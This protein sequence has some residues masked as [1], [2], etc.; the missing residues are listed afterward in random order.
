MQAGFTSIET[1]NSRTKTTKMTLYK[2]LVDHS[3]GAVVWVLFGWGLYTGRNP[4][5]AGD[6]SH[7]FTE[8]PVSEYPVVFQ[9]FGFAATAA[10]I[11]S[12]GVLGRIRLAPYFF[13]SAFSTGIIY[14]IVAHS[15]WNSNGFLAQLGYLDFAGS[16]IVHL[17][18][19]CFGFVGAWA[20]GPRVHRFKL[21]PEFYQQEDSDDE[22]EDGDD[23]SE[24][25]ED[26]QPPSRA[27][28]TNNNTDNGRI[29]PIKPINPNKKKKKPGLT[30]KE[31]FLAALCPSRKY[32]YVREPPGSSA[33]LSALGSLLLFVA[34]FC[35][36]AGS[37]L[38]IDTP[39]KYNTAARAALN[40]LLSYGAASSTAFFYSLGTSV[41]R[42]EYHIKYDLNLLINGG[43]AGLVVVT[44][45]C[46]YI[47]PWAA[48]LIGIIS[49]FAYVAGDRLI[50]RVLMID[51]PL[52][53]TAVHGVNGFL[54]VVWIGFAHRE[55]GIFYGGDGSMLGIQILGAIYITIFS[56][57]LAALFF[58]P[59]KL[60]KRGIYLFHD[61]NEQLVGLD[62][63]HFDHEGSLFVQMEADDLDSD[64]RSGHNSNTVR[65]ASPSFSGGYNN[66]IT[67][68]RTPQSSSLSI[69]VNNTNNNEP[70][71]SYAYGNKISG[72][73]K[74]TD[75][76]EVRKPGGGGGG[77]DGDKDSQGDSSDY[78]KNTA[79]DLRAVM[80]DRRLRKRFRHYLALTR[81]DENIRFY[82]HVEKFQAEKNK[83]KRR[84]RAKVIFQ[85]FILDSAPT[86]INL[87]SKLKKKLEEYYKSDNVEAL[88]SRQLFDEASDEL[89]K[90]LRE[91]FRIWT[92]ATP[93]YW[94]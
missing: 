16:S 42:S 27:G 46:A 82:D 79:R 70:T 80:D 11:T 55:H 69:R 44:G 22:N 77:G 38:A 47:D 30:R 9:Q 71:L 37:G 48:I 14:P 19:G 94:Q 57:I 56:T 61:K 59:L 88:S 15:T 74:A 54:G 18:G 72:N 64:D 21:K 62:F 58:V 51:D 39:D 83:D 29:T 41:S 36:N 33:E 73:S 3:I 89:F 65:S 5:L 91:R 67:P 92:E 60:Y 4:F 31:K 87:A 78:G 53:V 52:N 84:Q 35:F 32:L 90:D 17:V 26:P 25:I 24:D 86:Q 45:P 63:I 20:C 75:E 66:T 81:S 8:I 43:L 7:F 28:T 50:S 1:G 6:G 68:P 23:S 40:T 2:N 93:G 13:F 12:G 76:F 85:K 49:L 10:T 34:W